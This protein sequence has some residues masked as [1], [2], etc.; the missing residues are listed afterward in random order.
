MN[1]HFGFWTSLGMWWTM[2]WTR[3]IKS[4]EW[5][6]CSRIQENLRRRFKGDA[7]PR[8]STSRP[9]C[10]NPG[11]WQLRNCRRC[12][13]DP[14]GPISHLRNTHVSSS[15]VLAL[16]KGLSQASPDVLSSNANLHN[17]SLTSDVSRCQ[18]A[19]R[20]HF[21]PN[22][23]MWCAFRSHEYSADLKPTDSSKVHT[24]VPPASFTP[25][26]DRSA[27][28]SVAIPFL[29]YDARTTMV[30]SLQAA[31]L[32]ALPNTNLKS[33][34]SIAWFSLPPCSCR[35]VT[36]LPY[37]SKHLSYDPGQRTSPHS[38]THSIS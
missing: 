11:K 23:T 25:Y 35:H 34:V 22:C 24:M 20:D 7:L 37:L 13:G 6:E 18:K 38:L 29:N 14:L 28:F 8:H 31:D 3:G 10:P 32:L 36:G 5:E 30:S 1:G 4:R 15:L 33:P 27:I 26:A 17:S 12:L 16:A 2:W 9:T 21:S 19:P